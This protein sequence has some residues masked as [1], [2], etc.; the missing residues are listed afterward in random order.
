ML[1]VLIL[2]LIHTAL[3]PVELLEIQLRLIKLNS[4][5]HWPIQRRTYASPEGLLLA[6]LCYFQVW[7]CASLVCT[8][9]TQCFFSGV[10]S[11]GHCRHINHHQALG[12]SAT[13]W[14]THSMKTNAALYTVHCYL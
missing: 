5:I 8:L 1:S 14:G 2:E 11:W 9:C 3:I 4:Q 12:P 6:E 10:P 13:T 7:L